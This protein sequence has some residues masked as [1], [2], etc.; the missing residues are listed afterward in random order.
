MR[1]GPALREQTL[2]LFE[3]G[4]KGQRDREQRMTP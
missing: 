1:M 4:S 2:W 3:L